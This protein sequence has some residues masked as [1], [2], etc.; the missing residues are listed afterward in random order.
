MSTAQELAAQSATDAKARGDD[1]TPPEEKKVDAAKVE[2]EKTAKDAADLAE[3][4]KLAADGKEKGSEEDEDKGKGKDTRIPL[5]RHKSILE[6]ER[7]AR[8]VLEAKLAQYERGND[9]AATNEA[10]TKAESDLITLEERHAKEVAD[11][12]VATAN[13]TNAEI[14]K[15]DKAISTQRVALATDAA[16]AR[17]YERVRYDTVVER[18]EEAYPMMNP[19]LPDE[20]D[21]GKV[22]SVTRMAKAFQMEGMTPAKA[23]QEAVKDIL[24]EP[25]TK[26]QTA[27]V[28][29]T[30]KVTEAEAAAASRKEA[31]TKRALDA[32]GKQP[33][34]AA[35]VGQNSDALGGGLGNVDVMK[36]NQDDFAKLD[37]AELSRLRGDLF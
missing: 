23:L 37:E 28:D 32:D 34:T 27:A 36:L 29:V 22:A 17:A 18:I 20:Y 7:I 9:F 5:A 35:K 10:L 15:L 6:A 25:T 8:D 16:E 1:Y 21:K 24:G 12:E 19:D 31:A 13:K 30:P 11:G 14:R 33:P 26:K 4:E 2:E 3:V